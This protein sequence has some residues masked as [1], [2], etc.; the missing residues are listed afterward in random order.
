[1]RI[2]GADFKVVAARACIETGIRAV[3]RIECFCRS[4]NIC[5]DRVDIAYIPK[6]LECASRSGNKRIG[7]ANEPVSGI[8]GGFEVN[9]THRL[10]VTTV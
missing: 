1:M 6:R 3:V 2:A 5:G 7:S 9:I 4:C 8:C 10:I